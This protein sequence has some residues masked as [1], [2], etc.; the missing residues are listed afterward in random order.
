MP[1]VK[2]A[3]QEEVQKKAKTTN[4]M[5]FVWILKEKISPINVLWIADSVVRDLARMYD[6][7][8]RG[9]WLKDSFPTE[10]QGK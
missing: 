5:V 9:K 4:N 3:R 1:K 8:L 6:N 2:R 10:L 7:Y